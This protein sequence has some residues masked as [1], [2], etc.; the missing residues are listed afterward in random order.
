MNITKVKV[1]FLF[2][3][4][5]ITCSTMAHVNLK[6]PA[7]GETYN[8]GETVKIEWEE[9]VAHD[10]KNWDLYFSIDGG[11]T[12]ETVASDISV[13]ILSYD[14]TVPSRLSKEARI[15]V[16]Q[17]NSE[18][19]YSDESGN[20]TIAGTTTASTGILTHSDIR[21]F[22]NPASGFV[23]IYAN[24][25]TSAIKYVWVADNT[26]RVMDLQKLARIEGKNEYQ[27][28][29]SQWPAGIYYMT[30]LVDKAIEVR[31]LVVQ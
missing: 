4:M 15:K 9:T 30:I 1:G 17:D 14:W 18:G 7:G 8:P 13:N 29:I 16:V 21:L 12:Y 10:T 6:S 28:D 26:G 25:L 31:K 11:K 22:P 19:D 5:M 3:G 2:F 24:K 23:K 20:F 27:L